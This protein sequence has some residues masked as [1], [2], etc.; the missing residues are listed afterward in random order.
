MKANVTVLPADAT[1]STTQ[2]DL[3]AMA[4]GKLQELV[5][6]GNELK[7]TADFVVTNLGGGARDYKV[8]AGLLK[9]DIEFVRF[10]PDDLT[11]FAGDTVTW[12]TAGTE[13]PTVVIFTSG[14]PPPEFLLVEPQEAG[15]PLFLLNSALLPP[16]GGDTCPG[17]GVASSGF[18]LGCAGP[19]GAPTTYTLRFDTPGSYDYSSPIALPFQV[20][21]IN[22]VGAPTPPSVGDARMSPLMGSVSG[23]ARDHP[24]PGR[25]LPGSK[26]RKVVADGARQ[27]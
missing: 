16:Q 10:F 9:D 4:A 19:P 17:T 5:G 15:P 3:D 2:A 23:P 24:G 25:F 14:A 13:V 20:G 1:L 21:R 6:L 11:V 7:A 18:L 26:A 12:E 22:V 27:G 8:T